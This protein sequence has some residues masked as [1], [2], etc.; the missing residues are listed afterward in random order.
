M[1]INLESD[2]SSVAQDKMMFTN[3]IGQLKRT[4]KPTGSGKI[5]YYKEVYDHVHERFFR[6]YELHQYFNEVFT[7][8]TYNCVSGCAIYALVFDE[9]GIDYS[10]KETPTHVYI[11]LESDGNQY[12]IETTDPSGRFNKFSK[13]FKSH[14]IKQLQ[15]AKLIDEQEY[16]STDVEDLFEKYYFT[17]VSLSLK[18]LIGVQY[19]ND[20]IYKFQEEAYQEAANSFKKCYLL[21]PN[22]KVK[23]ML[24]ATLGV[25]ASKTNYQNLEDVALISGLSRYSESEIGDVELKNEFLRLTNYQLVEKRDIVLY[26]KSY[27]LLLDQIK[28]EKLKSEISFAYNY[29]RARLLH[30]RGRY[31]AA[32]GYAEGAYELKPKNIDA[33]SL[34]LS[35]LGQ[36]LQYSRDRVESYSMLDSLVQNHETL[37]ENNK[38]GGLFLNMNLICMAEYYKENKFGDGNYHKEKFESLYD[39]NPFFQVDDQLIGHAYSQLAVYYFKRGQYTSARKVLKKGMTYAPYNQELKSRMRA[40]NY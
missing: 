18:E 39:A 33:E 27:E 29:E 1:A 3:E 12:L 6:K 7:D 19:W 21:Y 11:V 13:N 5:K 8:G 28:R 30:N 10:I 16:R 2:P 36:Y 22:E 26:E 4:N 37:L 35:T 40:V 20:G 38:F 25:L 17:D 15:A 32:I 31:R 14:F 23:D 9:L 24:L 34:F